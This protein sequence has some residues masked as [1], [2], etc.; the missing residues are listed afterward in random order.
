MNRSQPAEGLKLELAPDACR[1]L[2]AIYA[3]DRE[4]FLRL[5]GRA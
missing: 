2:D 1:L 4:L 5:E 3:A